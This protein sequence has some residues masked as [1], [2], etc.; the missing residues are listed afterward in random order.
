MKKSSIPCPCCSGQTYEQCCQPYHRG[1]LP[2]N[3]LQLMRSRYS[4][5]A[6]NNP[7]YIM[8]T[9]HPANPK[10]KEDRA[11]WKLNI[12]EFSRITTFQKLEILDFQDQ[13]PVSTVTFKAHLSRGGRD[14][15]YIEKSSFEKINN[16]WLYRDGQIV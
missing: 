7:E 15:T 14:A 8:A 12:V 3:A 9:T 4:A 6:L 16:Q 2:K 13:E 10:Y 1:S 11:A 5:Y